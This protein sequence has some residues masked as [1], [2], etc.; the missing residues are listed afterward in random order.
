M[1]G[2]CRGRRHVLGDAQSRD[3]N[4]H[5]RE[6]NRPTN[7]ENMVA[8]HCPLVGSVAVIG[9]ARP[10][11]TALICLD[12]EVAAAHADNNGLEKRSIDASPA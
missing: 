2:P 4:G 7:I 3:K 5:E 6:T 10:Y 8:V 11:N 9:D 1:E 12:P